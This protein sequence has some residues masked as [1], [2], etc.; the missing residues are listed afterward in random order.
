M[1][2]T[3]VLIALLAA[4][5]LLAA[6]TSLQFFQPVPTACAKTQVYQDEKE[7]D[8]DPEDISQGKPRERASSSLWMPPSRHTVERPPAPR[9]WW[10]ALMNTIRQARTVLLGRIDL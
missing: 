4:T 10:S 5:L 9:T 7:K 8:G 3:P 6:P 1:K 2:K